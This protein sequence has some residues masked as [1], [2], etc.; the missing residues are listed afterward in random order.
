[1]Q[2]LWLDLNQ[3][4]TLP[5]EFGKL[6]SLRFLEASEN[7][8]ICLPD[9]FGKLKSLTDLYLHENL[10]TDLPDS[11]GNI[12]GQFIHSVVLS[13]IKC[14][15]Q[16][17]SGWRSFPNNLTLHTLCYLAYLF[18]YLCIHVYAHIYLHVRICVHEYIC[19]V[20]ICSGCVF[21]CRK[22]VA[23]YNLST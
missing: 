22:P 4:D 23:P 13:L 5:P 18:I 2:D 15:H 21:V 11:F 14:N 12:C 7:K 9:T 8:M 16:F 1:M 3:L 19:E 6:K 10:L 17:H 20:R